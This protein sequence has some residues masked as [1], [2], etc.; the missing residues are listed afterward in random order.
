MVK[1]H[2]SGPVLP[3]LFEESG[4]TMDKFLMFDGGT[5]Q[6]PELV[7]L[8]QKAAIFTL[9]FH[10]PSASYRNTSQAH[11]KDEEGVVLRKRPHIHIAKLHCC[12]NLVFDVFMFLRSGTSEELAAVESSILE[13]ITDD[14]TALWPLLRAP[15]CATTGSPSMFTAGQWLRNLTSFLA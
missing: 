6:S 11:V 5:A 7:L 12:D 10:S 13:A 2:N 14:R 15:T 3:W 9:E 4:A 8:L 1:F